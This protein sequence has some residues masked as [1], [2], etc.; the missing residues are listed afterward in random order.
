MIQSFLQYVY[1]LKDLN[2]AYI[3]LI[4]RREN[5]KE[6]NDYRQISLCNVS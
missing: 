1:I 6:V 5:P 3:S 2:K 4:L